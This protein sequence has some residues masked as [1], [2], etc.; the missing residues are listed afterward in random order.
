MIE[1]ESK[2]FNENKDLFFKKYKDSEILQDVQNFR[3][4][5]SKLSLTI[6]HFLEEIIY[7]ARATMCKFTPM[8][9]LMDD[10]MMVDVLDYIKEKPNF[11]T[12]DDITNIKKF[13][14]NS[15]KYARKVSNFD[16]QNAQEI[17][18][19]YHDIYE[20]QLNI[21]DTSC[22][23]GSRMLSVVLNA[24]NY[25]GTDPNTKLNNKLHE[26]FEFLK[27]YDYTRNMFFDSNID[28]RCQGSEIHIPEWDNRM[29]VMFTSPPYFK[30]EEYTKEETQSTIKFDDYKLWV[31]G[32][33]N[34]T[35]SNIHKYLKV[36]GVAMINI[37]NL[38]NGKKEKLYDDFYNAFISN[39]F[40]YIE[41][42]SMEHQNTKSYAINSDYELDTSEPIMAFRKV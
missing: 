30:L 27:K 17:Y 42:F 40:E 20:K 33:V 5:Q 16:P 24:H 18:F 1:K 9:V 34:P 36:G 6:R 32:F 22:G 28:I 39:G 13:L 10:E 8:E 11:Y 23:F 21:L 29:D 4:G 41:T 15:G 7:E 26:M 35:V 37:K 3:D 19:R 31:Q 14:Q 12:D 25:Y 2:W 38:T